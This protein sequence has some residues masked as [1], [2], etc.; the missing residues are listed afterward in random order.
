M[1]HISLA[2]AG[3]AYAMFSLLALCVIG[4]LFFGERIT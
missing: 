4:S 2:Q 1:R 3:V